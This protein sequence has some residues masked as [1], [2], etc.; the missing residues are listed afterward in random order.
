MKNLKRSLCNVSSSA[1]GKR[2]AWSP[3]RIQGVAFLARGS[4]GEAS[5]YRLD[6]RFYADQ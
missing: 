6:V 2:V 1:R 5:E 4:R 3:K